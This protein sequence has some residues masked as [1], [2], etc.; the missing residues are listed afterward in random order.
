MFNLGWMY[1]NGLGVEQDYHLAKRWYDLALATN[2]GSILPVYIATT[3]LSIKHSVFGIYSF[4]LEIFSVK[5]KG[6]KPNYRKAEPLPGQTFIEEEQRLDAD[7]VVDYE[8][9]LIMF[10]ILVVSILYYYRTGVLARANNMVN[11]PVNVMNVPA[12]DAPTNSA[13]DSASNSLSDSASNSVN[14]AVSNDV[15]PNDGVGNPSNDA[16]SNLSNDAV[17]NLSNDAVDNLSNDNAANI[18]ADSPEPPKNY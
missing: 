2:P 9:L 8:D 4:I 5:N 18:L 12:N 3:I 17:D 16:V 10:L 7:E 14:D 1:E 11:N 15:V 13:D 6:L